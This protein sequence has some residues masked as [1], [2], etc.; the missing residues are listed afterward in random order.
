M[1]FEIVNIDPALVV[2]TEKYPRSDC[3]FVLE[4]LQRYFSHLE[5]LPAIDI[6]VE[7]GNVLVSKNHDYLITAK[8]LERTRIRAITSNA[9]AVIDAV[10]RGN[11]EEVSLLDLQK[12]EQQNA[13]QVMWHVFFLRNRPSTHTILRFCEQLID[14]IEKSVSEVLGKRTAIQQARLDR[15]RGIVE[16]KFNTPCANECWG[17]GLFECLRTLNNDIAEIASY[18]GRELIL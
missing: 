5:C 6:V 13:V 11:A 4:H 8:A 3:G 16:V 12:E 1:P 17:T 2:E 18:Q 7:S 15:Q 14:Y 9:A 10:G